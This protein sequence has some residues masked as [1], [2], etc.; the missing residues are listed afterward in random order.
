[1]FAGSDEVLQAVHEAIPT[2][3]HQVSERRW[4]SDP[5]NAI[6]RIIE[7]QAVKGLRYSA[8]WGFSIDFV[9]RLS[10]VRLS[11]KRTL[12]TADFD[13]TIDPIDIDRRGPQL[14]FF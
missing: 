3:F 14:V 5:C 8:R 4:V 12:K 9:P 2:D 10:G 7:F 13:L 6:R 1:M 11:W